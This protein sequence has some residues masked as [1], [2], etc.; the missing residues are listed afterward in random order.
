MGRGRRGAQRGGSEWGEVG[1]EGAGEGRPERRERAVGA[2]GRGRGSDGG[3]REGGR[4]VWGLSETE[5]DADQGDRGDEKRAQG[6]TGKERTS[7]AARNQEERDRGE[8]WGPREVARATART[9]GGGEMEEGC[10]EGGRGRRP[11]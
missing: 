6:E 4:E 11:G 10:G 2:E 1:R 9:P 3:G 7:G 8:W 5:M